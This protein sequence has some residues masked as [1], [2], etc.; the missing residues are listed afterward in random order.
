MVLRNGQEVTAHQTRCICPQAEIH[1]VGLQQAGVDHLATL[2]PP[3]MKAA[4]TLTRGRLP[5]TA[6]T[7]VGDRDVTDEPQGWPRKRVVQRSGNRP[8]PT[9]PIANKGPK[10]AKSLNSGCS[11]KQKMAYPRR[12][13]G[14]KE[15]R[16]RLFQIFTCPISQAKASAHR[17][18]TQIYSLGLLGSGPH[19][20]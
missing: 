8:S 11:Q 6:C 9:H 13:E 16:L 4:L 19:N 15:Y 5:W 2:P 20:Q 12:P 1:E 3:K 14:T 17:R 18:H 10:E 7:D